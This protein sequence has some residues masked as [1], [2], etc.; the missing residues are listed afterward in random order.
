MHQYVVAYDEENYVSPTS[1]YDEDVT[2][3]D[4]FKA[5]DNEN[6]HDFFSQLYKDAAKEDKMPKNALIQVTDSSLDALANKYPA[7]MEV[8]DLVSSVLDAIDTYPDKVFFY[9]FE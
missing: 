3:G 2:E 6:I 1:V 5:K 8:S 9:T 4:V 7:D